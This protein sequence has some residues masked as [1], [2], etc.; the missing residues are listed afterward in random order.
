M[1]LVAATVS[2]GLVSAYAM[3]IGF[4]ALA[5]G[6]MGF[7]LRGILRA[8]RPASPDDNVQETED[9]EQLV[10]EVEA[11]SS[12][13]GH[14]RPGATFGLVGVGDLLGGVNRTGEFYNRA[15]GQMDPVKQPGGLYGDSVLGHMH[16]DDD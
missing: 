14:P 5:L 2:K 6:G 16:D 10:G 12:E 3:I 4:S 11:V 8:L 13:D 7:V 15:T 1:A 9:Q